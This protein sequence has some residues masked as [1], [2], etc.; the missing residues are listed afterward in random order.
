MPGGNFCP[1]VDIKDTVRIRNKAHERT[2]MN[3]KLSIALLIALSVAAV[4]SAQVSTTGTVVVTIE[5]QDNARVPGV[6]VTASATDVVSKRM[7]VTDAEG[8]ATLD[9]LAPSALYTVSAQLSGFKELVRENIL[10]RSGSTTTL[11]LALSLATL[12]ET[13]T[14]SAAT[15]VVDTTN[16]KT[17]QDITLQLVPGVMPDNPTA[18]GNPSAK[19]GLNYADIDGQ[20]GVSADNF[21]YLDGINVTD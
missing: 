16:A 6:T 7:A 2:R 18:P 21:Y 1:F 11:H 20:A 5:D 12:A 15:P 10:V 8:N 3:K 4:A 9:G 17:G 19:S 14:V 13:V